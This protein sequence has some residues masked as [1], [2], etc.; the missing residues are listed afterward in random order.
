MEEL[1]TKPILSLPLSVLPYEEYPDLSACP[2]C[3]KLGGT[4]QHV[5][6]VAYRIDPDYTGYIEVQCSICYGIWAINRAHRAQPWGISWC[7][8]HPRNWSL[9]ERQPFAIENKEFMQLKLE[10]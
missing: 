1:I 2:R 4:P 10:I 7:I 3:G 6:I 9:P 8:Q 5:F